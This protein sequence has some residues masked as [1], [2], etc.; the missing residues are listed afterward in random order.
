MA[1]LS[2]GDQPGLA[3]AALQWAYFWYNFMP[4]ARGTALVGY[5]SLLALFLAAD[6]PIT[7]MAPKV[8]PDT[9]NRLFLEHLNACIRAL[10]SWARFPCWRCFLAA[11]M[12][13]TCM[14]TRAA[15]SIAKQC[16]QLAAF[17]SVCMIP[18]G[19]PAGLG[20]HLAAAARGV[21]GRGVTLAVA[22][23]SS[24]AADAPRWVPRQ[25]TQTPMR[26]TW[27]MPTYVFGLRRS[28][29]WPAGRMLQ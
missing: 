2:A 16:T 15:C 5:V 10:H 13:I 6:M 3:Q 12:P 25:T 24:P 11:Y 9:Q 7:R 19:L 22:T 27:F 8:N 28:T 29:A 18:T 26:H 20:G 14:A 23:S 21:C 1:A 4:L 17:Y